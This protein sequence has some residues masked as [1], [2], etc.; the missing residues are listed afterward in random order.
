M[1][2]EVATKVVKEIA[3]E[4]ASDVVLKLQQKFLMTSQQKLLEID[5]TVAAVKTDAVA[6][7]ATI[8]VEFNENKSIRRK[9]CLEA[10]ETPIDVVIPL[11]KSTCQGINVNNAC[12]AKETLLAA[13]P[14]NLLLKM[15]GNFDIVGAAE[16][17]TAAIQPPFAS[18]KRLGVQISA[19]PLEILDFF[20]EFNRVT[21]S[22]YHPQHFWIFDGAEVDF[23]GYSAP[24]DGVQFLEV[25]WKKYRN[26]ITYF[27]LR[28]FGGGAMLILLCC[29]LAQMRNTNFDNV[30]EAKRWK[31]IVQELMKEV[32]LQA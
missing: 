27:K 2:E 1:E 32:L 9:R 16:S 7:E 8:D 15:K 3:A 10:Q 13:V 26:F 29:V 24:R 20:R 14:M 18:L 11:H 22:Q 5:H 4:A 31:S 19:V 17:A 28:I 12:V 25:M 6:A 23:Y 21:V 30:T